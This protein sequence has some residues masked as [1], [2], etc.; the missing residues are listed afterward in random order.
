MMPM[1]GLKTKRYVHLIEQS[2]V[3]GMAL[4]SRRGSS[5]RYLRDR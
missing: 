5:A 2:I 3:I 4:L 1:L